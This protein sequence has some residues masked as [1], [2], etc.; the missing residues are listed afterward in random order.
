MRITR[1]KYDSKKPFVV[2][3]SK[4][5]F[6]RIEVT[7]EVYPNYLILPVDVKAEKD[8]LSILIPPVKTYPPLTSPKREAKITPNY[9]RV[10]PTLNLPN[11]KD[12]E[13]TELDLLF[14]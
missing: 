13:L 14:I 6:D 9:I 5:E 8:S 2:I 10:P 12:Y 11:P 4:K 7:E 1:H 3:K